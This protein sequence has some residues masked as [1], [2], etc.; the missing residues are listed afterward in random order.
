MKPS[1][2]LILILSLSACSNPEETSKHKD[3]SSPA[4]S[5]VKNT[6][7]SQKENKEKTNP[8][9]G[10]NNPSAP[11]KENDEELSGK[12][13]LGSVKMISAGQMSRYKKVY[14][15]GIPFDLVAEKNDTTYFSTDDK[16]FKTPEGF[17]IGTKFSSLPKNFR[18]DLTKEAG[19]GYYTE[20]PSGWKLAF[21]EGTSCTDSTPKENS[22]VK[23][24][25]KRR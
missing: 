13:D 4:A 24:I 10:G 16:R 23:W 6:F 12:I 17:S 2:I 18:D 11:K 25:F 15:K 1:I 3:Q 14:I 20:L 21:C 7:D 5:S 9:V 8:V 22:E 19:W